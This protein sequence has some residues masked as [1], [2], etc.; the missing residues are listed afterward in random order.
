MEKMADCATVAPTLLS[1]KTVL[2]RPSACGAERQRCIIVPTHL[3]HF[4]VFHR[5]LQS[6]RRWAVD[7]NQVTVVGVFSE[8]AAFSLPHFCYG[9]P[10][11]CVGDLFEGT[12]LERLVDLD[13]Y[14]RYR[15]DHRV[16]V[17]HQAPVRSYARR[18]RDA[19]HL[20]VS[21]FG[22]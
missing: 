12:D 20:A 16:R 17:G 7:R 11:S 10:S 4:P 1:N 22:R 15:N 2:L 5:L 6:I 21:H 14:S 3:P 19:R 13:S 18:H 9:F 8:E